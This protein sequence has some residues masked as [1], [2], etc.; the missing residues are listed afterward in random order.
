MRLVRGRTYG[1]LPDTHTTTTF[2]EHAK[3]DLAAK[4]GLLVI[5]KVISNFGMAG[6]VL[7]VQRMK[8]TEFRFS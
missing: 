6:S 1:P 2:S 3:I 4:F 7:G 5:T 8:Y